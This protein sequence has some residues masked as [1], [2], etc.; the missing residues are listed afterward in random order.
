MGFLED[1]LQRIISS[2]KDDAFAYDLKQQWKRFLD[3]CFILWNRSRQDL[4]Y[5]N[6]TL[7]SLH[8]DIKFKMEVSDK[9]LPFLDSVVIKNG[10]SL[11]TDI[12]F[13]DTDSQQYLNFKSC[14][15]KHTKTNIPYCLA[16]RICTIV[17]DHAIL[18]RRLIELTESLVNRG[19]PLQ[20]IMNGIQN[21]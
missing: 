21:Y 2:E 18:Q 13:K 6:E 16:R 4:K 3:D 19:Y 10:T 17:S 14:H 5:F 20:I 8:G 1:K 12:Y 15:P 7:N 11:S 9:S